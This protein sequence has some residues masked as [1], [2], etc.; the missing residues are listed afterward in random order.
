MESSKIQSKEDEDKFWQANYDA[1][2]RYFEDKVGPLPGDIMK[3]MNM[4]GV[5]PGGGLFVI[6]APKLGRDL[7]VYTTF[8]FTNSDMP[9]SVQAAAQPPVMSGG[10]PTQWQSTLSRKEPAPQRPGAAGYGYEIMMV[11]QSGLAWPLNFLQWTVRAEINHDAG[12]LDRVEK[13]DGLT[14][15]KI[16]VGGNDKMAINVL[17]AKAQAPLPTGAQLPAGSME[18]LVA[19]TITEEE[20]RWTMQHGRGILVSKLAE[21]GVGQISA[22]G[23]GSAV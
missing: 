8:G 14:V 22:P 9:T 10:R 1:R 12:L 20:M 19:T 5:W 21:A 15:E 6:P 11:A 2:V 23:R 4:M 18:I 7:S 3:M 16:E 17:I 13:Y